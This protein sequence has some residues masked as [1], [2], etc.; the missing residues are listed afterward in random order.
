MFWGSKGRIF[1]WWV[2]PGR[3]CENAARPMRPLIA[4]TPFHECLCDTRYV[5]F[6]AGLHSIVSCQNELEG[7]TSV[8]QKG[9]HPSVCNSCVRVDDY[10]HTANP[11]PGEFMRG[12]A[13]I[14]TQ[15]ESYG[16]GSCAVRKGVDCIETARVVDAGASVRSQA[17]CLI[18]IRSRSMTHSSIVT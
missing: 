6:E 12:R 7:A 1:K 17:S 16:I 3:A 4:N 2:C 10:T 15:L 9:N 14:S 13:G 8:T 5:C 18:F 11:F